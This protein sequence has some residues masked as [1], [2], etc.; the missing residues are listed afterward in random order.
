MINKV[1]L[2]GR[3][4]AAPELKSTQKGEKLANFSVATSE[5][6]VDKSGESKE[7]VEWHKIVCFGGLAETCGKYLQKGMQVYIE[8]KL[9]TRSWEDKDGEKRFTTSVVANV[10]RFLD[11]KDNVK[12]KGD[13]IPW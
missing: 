6:W 7:S 13:G 9:Q 11:S 1:I 12:S 5:K 4:G 2:V 8:G 10:V 3:L